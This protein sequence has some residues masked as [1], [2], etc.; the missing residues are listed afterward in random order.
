M[1]Q[2]IDVC[3]LCHKMIH[4]FVPSEKELGRRYNTLDLLL[5]HPEI[6]K[7]VEWKRSKSRGHSE[8]VA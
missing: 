7:Y 6:N 5:T 8:K 1:S 2:G 4:A 3:K